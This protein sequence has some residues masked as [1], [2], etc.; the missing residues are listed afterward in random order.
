[1]EKA[2][3]EQPSAVFSNL[4]VKNFSSTIRRP[5]E[6]IVN[7]TSLNFNVSKKLSRN[8]GVDQKN[9]NRDIKLKQSCS[10]Y[11]LGSLAMPYKHLHES[12]TVR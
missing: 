10:Q 4:R 2:A 8:Q 11:L 12:K 5:S 3:L 9:R 1:M 6:A 7:R